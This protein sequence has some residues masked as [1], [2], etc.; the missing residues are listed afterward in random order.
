MAKLAIHKTHQNLAEDDTDTPMSL[1]PE[2]VHK[3]HASEP[4]PIDDD[5]SRNSISTTTESAQNNAKMAKGT[6]LVQKFIL[7]ISKRDELK[8]DVDA[9]FKDNL[10][11]AEEAIKCEIY[12]ELIPA[13]SSGSY[14]VRNKGGEFLAVFKPKDEEPFASLNPKWPKF[15]QRILCFCCFG[16]ACLIPNNGYLS[17]TGASL[18][19]DRLK[20]G[21]VPKTRL[22]KLTSPTFSYNKRCGQ[23]R[24]ISPKE[25]SY[26]IFVHGY[27]PATEVFAEW[28]DKGISNVLT[29]AEQHE[30]T[31]YFQKLVVLDYLI[32]NTDR[33]MD[34]WLIKHIPGKELKI[35][36]IDNGLA[37]PV[38]HPETA[39][40]FRQFPF[41]WS[42][43]TWAKKKW[44][45]ELTDHF[46]S[47]LTPKNVHFLCQDLK[48]LF[49]H[50]SSNSQ[51]INNQ[52]RVFRGQVWNL[53]DS[54][55]HNESPFELSKR[56][57]VLL[58]RRYLT[59]IP[60]TNNWRDWY[61]LKEM[62]YSN[63]ACC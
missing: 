9:D 60:N 19:D 41:G 62:D 50:G 61:K 49:K 25:G 6:V 28:N 2:P 20:L 52:L 1:K 36:A 33:H 55:R 29:D 16:R 15:F 12:P 37:F 14:F 51:L 46:L 39:S 53:V 24:E 59:T 17:E 48:A 40:R 56:T 10:R 47:L 23:K 21:I 18:L 44:E 30:F 45:K 63:R 35:A 4:L 31:V 54:M 5:V 58:A 7:S 27:R 32:R 22:V 42:T 8:P 26:Q 43:L 13:G 34:N 3:L 11:Q 38:K 57:P